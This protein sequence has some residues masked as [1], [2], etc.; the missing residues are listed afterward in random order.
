MLMAEFVYN[1]TKNASTDNTLFELNY[2]YHLNV[3]LKSDAN[4]RSRFYSA[5]KLI[6]ELRDMISIYQ[7]NLL[8]AQKLQK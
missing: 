2:G 1:N 3:L 5:D 6:K 8:Y 7:Q 4:S